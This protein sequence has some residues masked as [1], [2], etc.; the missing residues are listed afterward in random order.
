M[1]QHKGALLGL[2]FF[3]GIVVPGLLMFIIDSIH[4][5]A[6]MKVTAEVGEI[7]KEEG[8]VTEKVAKTVNDFHKRG[9]VIT[10]AD[11]KGQSVSSAV[12]Y[13]ETIVAHFTHTYT[14][15]FKERKLETKNKIEILKRNSTGNGNIDQG[16]IIKKINLSSD[17]TTTSDAFVQTFKIPGLK[18]ARGL[19]SDNGSAQVI[20]VSGEDVTIRMKNGSPTRQE[21]INDG[22]AADKKFVDNEDGP[23]YDKDGYKGT[24]EKYVASGEYIEGDSKLV[25]D[26]DSEDY[27]QDGYVGKLEKYLVS[28]NYMPEDS[29]EVTDTKKIEK[30]YE[31]KTV[32][33]TVT[34]D[35]DSFKDTID[36]NKDGFEGT[37][38]KQG[39][40]GAKVIDGEYIPAES[41]E[42]TETVSS[43][44]DSFPNTRD[45]SKDKFEGTLYKDGGS[46]KEVISG[47]Y[48]PAD[49]KYVEGYDSPDYF[50]DGF[51]GK[52]ERYVVS[53]E[54]KPAEMKFVS[55]TT[56]I[57]EEA[58]RI[59]DKANRDHGGILAGYFNDI[60]VETGPNGYK[61]DFTRTYIGVPTKEVTYDKLTNV[62][63]HEF[64]EY[65]NGE[66]VQANTGGYG[67]TVTFD[68][69][70]ED[71]YS[72]FKVGKYTLGDIVSSVELV[73]L[74]KPVISDSRVPNKNPNSSAYRPVVKPPKEGDY[75][76]VFTYTKA[77]RY[78]GL[79]FLGGTAGAKWL[80]EGMVTVPE[81][82]TR[83]YAY[84]GYVTKPE[85]DTR[86]YGY[87]QTYKGIVTKPEED[88][89]VLKYEQEYSGV[90]KK[91]NKDSFP[92][93]I[94][95]AE[96]GYVGTLTK[97][98]EAEENL[99]SG[100]YLPA[101]E[102]YIEGYD[103]SDY[104][105]D[106]Y[107]GTLEKYVASGE[108][109]PSDTK[110]VDNYGSPD[111]NKDGYVG[112]LEK[113]VAS[114][115]Y[116]TADS[117]YIKG[118]EAPV[119]S[120]D[121]NFHFYYYPTN[122]PDSLIDFS[123]EL[124]GNNYGG[125]GN[126]ISIYYKDTEG[127]EGWLDY[128]DEKGNTISSF[129]YLKKF[130]KEISLEVVDFLHANN[131]YTNRDLIKYIEQNKDKEDFSGNINIPLNH[132]NYKF[133]KK[134]DKIF[135]GGISVS[136][137]RILI[138]LK[139]LQDILPNT[140]VKYSG[141]VTRK[142]R[143]TRV[144][145][146]RG[147]VTKPEQDTR[148]YKYHGVVK[149]PESDTRVYEYVQKYMGIVT[150][151][152]MDTRI[153][154]YQGIVERPLLD[155]RVFKY[156]GYVTK[157]ASPNSGETKNFYQYNMV[158]EYEAWQ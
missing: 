52:L 122:N 10:F 50:K 133:L 64:L 109:S 77:Y 87:S 23:Y 70:D 101:D 86:E 154:K 67:I 31:E 47:S 73:D 112:K 145:K 119:R 115:E 14:C 150:R 81:E 131:L 102:K 153:Y 79:A 108:Y 128:L 132:N 104:D 65:R 155:T 19:T 72:S 60:D 121:S 123:K 46:I 148:V 48:T 146:Y 20:S 21:Q 42:V 114:G 113:Y 35:K 24:L 28:G 32:T 74:D 45:Y 85:E 97:D 71:N 126:S 93:T 111:Y 51:V 6:F 58:N 3:I 96:D 36:Y 4:E 5:H 43:S 12:D 13:G 158:L 39:N 29:K 106:G 41:K 53:G 142:E 107:K 33:E 37:L 103:S 9:Y 94:E 18:G 40:S 144:Y 130:S 75:A 56:N 27:N 1:S 69:K 118:H 30:A 78:K 98:G 143:D 105:Q 17:E 157:P 134:S 138:Y 11:S 92:E 7:V 80:Y 44:E 91:S 62:S 26:Y 90:V 156:K 8:G 135:G 89:R 140:I 110:Y 25:T 151:P 16:G 136:K 83:K 84:R 76:N 15:V 49:T 116:I 139:P 22:E 59:K 63:S 88:T 147:Y 38:S 99:A 100:E 137:N 152:E 2:V 61:G 117:K 141:D 125:S 68:Y 57:T 127:Y 82:D 95:Y 66:W 34:S 120:G 124:S 54:Y 149:S 55:F 129:A